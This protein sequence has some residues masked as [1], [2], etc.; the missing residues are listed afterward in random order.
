MTKADLVKELNEK[1]DMLNKAEE[2]R[3]ELKCLDGIREAAASGWEWFSCQPN[4]IYSSD[5]SEERFNNVAKRLKERGFYTVLI[6]TANEDVYLQ[7][8]LQ[9][10]K[11]NLKAWTNFLTKI[12]NRISNKFTK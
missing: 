6:R 8:F 11:D 1:K 2:D 10:P 5:Y 9:E 4:R 7:V 3:L 12:K